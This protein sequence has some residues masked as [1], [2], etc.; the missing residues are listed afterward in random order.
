M[1]ISWRNTADRWGAITKLMHWTMALLIFAATLSIWYITHQD[2]EHFREQSTLTFRAVMPWHKALGFFVLGLVALRLVWRA[3]DRRPDK[4]ATLK[5]WESVSASLA[6]L[7]LYGLTVACIL[8]GWGQV[9]SNGSVAAIFDWIVLPPLVAK[10]AA[11]HETFEFWHFWTSWALVALAALHA[12]AALKHHFV[13][14][15]RVL[16]MMWPGSR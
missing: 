15:D 16:R 9:S 14:R 10:D 13:D 11:L 6:H 7:A 2:F 8:L 4:V 12:A 5:P 3:V 1:S